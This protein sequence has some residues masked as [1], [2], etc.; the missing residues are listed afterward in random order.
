MNATKLNIALVEADIHWEDVSANLK[1]VQVQLASL[2]KE[3]DAVVF[4]EMYLSGFT[5][6]PERCFVLMDGIEINQLKDWSKEFDVAIAGSIVLKENDSYY[7]RFLWINPNG[8]VYQYDKKHLF[9]FAQEDESYKAGTQQLVVSYKGWEIACFVCYD[10][11][12]PVWCRNEKTR[13]DVAIFVAN[14]PAVRITA[15]DTLLKARSLENQSYVI[16]VN[17]VGEDGNKVKYDGESVI[18]DSFGES[19]KY[20]EEESVAAYYEL[21]KHNLL[22]HRSNFPVLKDADSF[23]REE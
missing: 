2:K 22:E 13:Y 11:R 3:V 7:N 4:P 9:T 19:V 5:M 10:L 17:R 12:F 18:Y 8:E 15:W 21:S 16:G 6:N 23:K 14:W 1:A 20:V